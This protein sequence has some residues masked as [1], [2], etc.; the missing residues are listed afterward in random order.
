MYEIDKLEKEF[1]K[2]ISLEDTDDGI[3][4]F[5]K[6]LLESDDNDVLEFHYSLLSRIDDAYLYR[7]ILTF[8]SERKNKIKVADF[9]YIKYKSNSLNNKLRADIIETLGVLN[10]PMSRQVAIENINNNSYEIR[11]K[12]IIAL[13][14]TGI[15]ED[16]KMLNE[17]MI[18]D[19]EGKLREYSATAMRQIWYRHPES[20]EIITNYIYQAV[21][22]ENNED[23]LIGMIVTIQDLYKKKFGI[24]ESRYGDVSGDVISA[25]EKMITFLNKIILK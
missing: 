19:M 3:F 15:I 8:F 25:K 2:L 20:K 7:D 12:S 9:L 17:R 13:G 22:S 4:D 10:T 5:K 23:A 11:Y 24:K 1:Y 21:Q 16:I 14:W 18:N 6:I